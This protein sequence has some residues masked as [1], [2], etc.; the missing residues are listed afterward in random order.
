M[1]YLVI[2]RPCGRYN[3]AREVAAQYLRKGDAVAY[4]KDMKRAGVL[5]DLAVV[6]QVKSDKI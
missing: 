5:R 3:A 6:K 4:A 2:G 1:V